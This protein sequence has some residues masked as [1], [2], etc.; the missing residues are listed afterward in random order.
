LDA[1]SQALAAGEGYVPTAVGITN[2]RETCL[3]WD[4]SG[5]PLHRAIVWQCRR[6]SGICTELR[7]Q[8]LEAQIARRT[9][10]RLDPYFSGTKALWLRRND[11]LLVLRIAS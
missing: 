10:L 5:R 8:G 9:G 4:R 3:F 11:P 7:D 2:Q 6:T 1:T